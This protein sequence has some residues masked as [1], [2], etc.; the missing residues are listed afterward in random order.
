MPLAIAA[1]VSA[2]LDAIPV[3]R[4]RGTACAGLYSLSRRRDERLAG[5]RDDLLWRAIRAG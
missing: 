4:S 1:R 5:G 2:A 3:E